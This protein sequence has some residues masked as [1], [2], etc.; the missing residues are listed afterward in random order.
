MSTKDLMNL[1]QVYGTIFNDFKKTI[2]KESTVPKGE[3]GNADLEQKG[4]PEETAGYSSDRVDIEDEDQK[5]NDYNIKG[6]SY[7]KGNNPGNTQ[8]PQPTTGDAALLGIVGDGDEDEEDTKNDEYPYECDCG[9]TWKTKDAASQCSTCQGHSNIH[10]E[11]EEILHETEK[12]ARNGLNNF[13]KR[14]SVFDKLYDKV[15]VSENFGELEPSDLDSLGLDDAVPDSELGD[16]GEDGDEITVTLDRSTAQALCDV[17]QAA[18]G[19]SEDGDEDFGAGDSDD[20]F[21]GFDGEEDEEGAPTALNTSYNDGKSNK[22]GSLKAKG[23]A[24]FKGTNIKV[25]TGST[26][27]GSYNDGKNNK[28]GNL[29]TN[30]SAFEQ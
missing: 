17:L 30:Q 14:K 19:H 28:V 13:M 5:S 23:G 27:S 20:G 22:V 12:I 6:L 8:S 4:G 15:M 21:D 18:I 16:E 3:I 11:D 7:G 29:K 1:G 26:H 24:T 25:D 10:D 9:E 2:V